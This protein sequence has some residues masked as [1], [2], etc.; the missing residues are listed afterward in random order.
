MSYHTCIP[1]KY[2]F[3]Y[4]LYILLFQKSSHDLR[5]VLWD[6]LGCFLD[7]LSRIGAGSSYA[8]SQV[9]FLSPFDGFQLICFNDDITAALVLDSLLQR[10]HFLFRWSWWFPA[11][12]F[13]I[14]I[15]IYDESRKYILRRNP[16]GFVERETYY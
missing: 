15:F 1:W 12:P 9:W 13:S 11:F 8:E 10:N 3:T 14:A 5:S 7:L 6:C 16:G 2:A 4:A